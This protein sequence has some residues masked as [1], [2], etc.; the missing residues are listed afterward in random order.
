MGIRKE[1]D[2]LLYELGLLKLLERHGKVYVVGSYRTDLMTHNDLDIDIEGNDHSIEGVFALAAD[3]N[4][5]LKPYRF[6]G[7]A[8]AKGDKFFY[9]CE[10]GITGE[11]WNLDI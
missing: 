8:A 4:A 2:R 1:A 3:V 9:G 11:R 6:E 5:L 10:T 7:M